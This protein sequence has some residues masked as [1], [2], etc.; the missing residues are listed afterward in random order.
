MTHSAS[1]RALSS[2]TK[3]LR[4]ST[5]RKIGRSPDQQ[6]GWRI[7]DDLVRGLRYYEGVLSSKHVAVI[8]ALIS[9]M[10]CDTRI[11]FAQNQ[12]LAARLHGIRLRTLG[13][14][15]K[16]LV[17]EGFLRRRTSP[18]CKRMRVHRDE[19]DETSEDEYYGLDLEPFYARAEEFAGKALEARREDAQLAALR[20]RVSRLRNYLEEIE[21]N[22]ELLPEISRCLRKPPETR[23]AERIAR[24]GELAERLESHLGTLP[25]DFEPKRQF[26]A[27]TSLV[28]PEMATNDGQ[29]DLHQQTRKD[30]IFST[31]A[32]DG[33]L[34][35]HRVQEICFDEEE[36]RLAPAPSAEPGTDDLDQAERPM[37]QQA[38]DPEGAEKEPV[39]DLVSRVLADFT[40]KLRDG[41]GWPPK[42]AAAASLQPPVHEPSVQA[43]ETRLAKPP[44]RPGPCRSLSL[45]ADPLPDL[46]Q[47]LDA[48]PEA[49]SM[50]ERRP[51]SWRDLVDAA[52]TI[53]RAIGLGE[54][55]MADGSTALGR[56]GLAVTIFGLCERLGSLRSPA[57][58]LRTLL[59]KP[60]FDPMALVL[61]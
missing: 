56:T 4:A 27:A 29:N 2:V 44:A 47:V 54:R 58:Y 43:G 5:G 36:G 45:A 9:F 6:L 38:P 1:P 22:A 25:Q 13:R 18:N 10:N 7:R 17:D 16:R 61:A 3:D 51:R 21:P 37:G 11:V 32:N 39:S 12:T 42:D 57:A 28:T 46:E 59:S 49:L 23:R 20:R 15:I 30:R 53:G 50:C 19:T 31:T 55:L 41:S 24:L 33:D 8:S 34:G 52:G 60:C 14:Q 40:R 48:C 26:G 35:R